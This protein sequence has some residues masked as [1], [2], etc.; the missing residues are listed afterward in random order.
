L[1][2]KC[3]PKGGRYKNASI[4]NSHTDSLA[5]GQPNEREELLIY[6]M[7]CTK[8]GGRGTSKGKHTEAEMI[9]ALKPIEAGRK[10]ADVA[11]AVGTAFDPFLNFLVAAPSRFLKGRCVCLFRAGEFFTCNFTCNDSVLAVFTRT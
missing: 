8:K 3:P 1:I 4:L 7:A 11:R 9:A 2:P 6:E 10:A 5:P